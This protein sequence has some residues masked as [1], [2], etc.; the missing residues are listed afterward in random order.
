MYAMT[1]YLDYLAETG[2]Q[3]P[4]YDGVYAA[5]AFSQVGFLPH[6]WRLRVWSVQPGRFSIPMDGVYAAV[7]CG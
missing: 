3:G 4:I 1:P 2:G 6:G 7:I 5:G